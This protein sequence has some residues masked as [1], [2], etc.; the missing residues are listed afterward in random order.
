[1]WKLYGSYTERN[2]GSFHRQDEL[3]LLWSKWAAK[4]NKTGKDAVVCLNKGEGQ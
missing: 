4:R 3:D 1:M 2:S